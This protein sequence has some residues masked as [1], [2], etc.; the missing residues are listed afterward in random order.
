MKVKFKSFLFLLLLAFSLKVILADYKGSKLQ[1]A[2][3]EYY[4]FGPIKDSEV[5]E[6]VES[7]KQEL[8]GIVS[9]ITKN[10]EDDYQHVSLINNLGFAPRATYCLARECGEDTLNIEFWLLDDGPHSWWRSK[11]MWGNKQLMYV[12][13]GI[14]VK[15]NGLLPHTNGFGD[16][17]IAP[18]GLDAPPV[19]A[20]ASDMDKTCW[21][22][23][24]DINWIIVL[25]PY[26]RGEY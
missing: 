18:Q 25:C 16:I 4:I 26:V 8:G 20:E 12:P 9:L 1:R 11:R 22:S 19:E 17:K 21:G 15:K 7:H 3:I 6:Y 10:P 24:I 13:G 5:A 14:K 23:P 2:S